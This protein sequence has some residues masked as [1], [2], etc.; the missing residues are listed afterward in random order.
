MTGTRASTRCGPRRG[1]ARNGSDYRCS[2]SVARSA[3]RHVT[4]G[5][6]SLGNSTPADSGRAAS[7][8]A[9]RRCNRRP[10]SW[11]RR[12]SRGVLAARHVRRLLG[13]R[14]GS[15]GRSPC[16]RGK[17]QGRP[18]APRMND[19]PDGLDGALVR[20]DDHPR[21]GRR[22]DVIEVDATHTLR[23]ADAA[24]KGTDR[25]SRRHG[26]CARL[27]PRG[28]VESAIA[29]FIIERLSPCNRYRGT[30]LP[31]SVGRWDRRRQE[32]GG[33]DDVGSGVVHVADG[34]AAVAGG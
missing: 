9:Q 8:S 33:S 32:P 15:A 26:G 29:N 30:G 20:L 17:R 24:S 27:S 23:P 16:R 2:A 13:G 22:S 25:A 18:L 14:A 1:T 3:G 10:R 4:P 21:V 31:S 19:R 34:G 28:D 12:A 11:C 6:T 5:R 7:A